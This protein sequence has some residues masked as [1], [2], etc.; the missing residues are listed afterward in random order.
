MSEMYAAIWLLFNLPAACRKDVRVTKQAL[1]ATPGLQ[2]VDKKLIRDG[3]DSMAIRY[4]LTPASVNISALVS[5][6]VDYSEINFI[7]VHVRD[8]KHAVKVAALLQKIIPKPVV[9]LLF[10]RGQ[11]WLSLAA[12]RVNQA[13]SQKVVIEDVADSGWLACEHLTSYEK[14]FSDSLDCRDYQ[15]GNLQLFYL[16]LMCRVL[17]LEAARLTGSFNLPDDIDIS[18]NKKNILLHV[19]RLGA[20]ITRLSGKAAMEK[21]MAKQ[22]DL[23]LAIKRVQVELE[24]AK[25]LL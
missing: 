21:Q 7:E 9:L 8:S 16:S 10:Y 25:S 17:E 23:N 12:K 1:L 2:A 20:E 3:L 14:I 22:I 19:A 11:W 13:D 18:W 4:L 6:A 24:I 15:W 5:D